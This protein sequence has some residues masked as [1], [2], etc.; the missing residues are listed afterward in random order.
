[1]TSILLYF[2]F[3]ARSARFKFL[4]FLSSLLII[5]LF[6]T[7]CYFY[8]IKSAIYLEH[9]ENQRVAETT[10]DVLDP[11]AVKN[12]EDL[13]NW[14]TSSNKSIPSDTEIFVEE[15]TEEAKKIVQRLNRDMQ[16]VNEIQAKAIEKAL[17]EKYS[18][19]TEQRIATI[20]AAYENHPELMNACSSIFESNSS[21][22]PQ[23][24]TGETDTIGMLNRNAD[25]NSSLATLDYSIIS[26]HRIPHTEADN[27][28][29]LKNKWWRFIP[30]CYL[31]KQFDKIIREKLS[32]NEPYN[33]TNEALTSIFAP[34]SFTRKSDGTLLATNY[35]NES[36]PNLRVRAVFLG[37]SI[38]GRISFPGTKFSKPDQVLY[39]PKD[40]P[41]FRL[42]HDDPNSHDVGECDMTTPYADIGSQLLVVRTIVCK[43]ELISK[44]NS[45]RKFALGVDLVIN[46]NR[47]TVNSELRGIAS[48]LKSTASPYENLNFGEVIENAENNTELYPKEINFWGIMT[49]AY[50]DLVDGVSS[51]FFTD[52]VIFATIIIIVFSLARARPKGFIYTGLVE[53]TLYGESDREN[54]V[55]GKEKTATFNRFIGFAIWRRKIKEKRGVEK[56]QREVRAKQI[57]ILMSGSSITFSL[58]GFIIELPYRLNW[59]QISVCQ[60]RNDNI[61]ISEA[62][63]SED[64]QINIIDE[65]TSQ[66]EYVDCLTDACTKSEKSPVLI[67]FLSKTFYKRGEG[68][69]SQVSSFRSL[70]K[71]RERELLLKRR[72]VRVRTSYQELKVLFNQSTINVVNRLTDIRSALKIS[73]KDYLDLL[74]CSTSDVK[75]IIVCSSHEE[76]NE[77]IESFKDDYNKIMK[78]H[79]QKKASICFLVT[80]STVGN[81]GF[82]TSREQFILLENCVIALEGVEEVTAKGEGAKTS[83][84][85]TGYIS[86]NSVDLHFYRL[87]HEE[88]NDFRIKQNGM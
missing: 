51:S 23:G 60:N 9:A 40:R 52:A 77:F 35:V 32:S 88:L 63:D 79:K 68:L 8:A 5:L 38:G 71:I 47:D 69:P 66:K 86:W 4:E 46:K 21:V 41:W 76:L 29:L 24:L 57:Y 30:N 6:G 48:R 27:F 12:Y 72:R 16:R 17:A 7:A 53:S 74:A 25:A 42:I 11:V 78:I 45:I 26:N 70:E 87:Y 61:S 37:V 28:D 3:L 36:D 22:L 43:G 83:I 2:D 59:Y 18:L 49:P 31:F 1:M 54:I 67:K 75:R 73:N 62:T 50:Y 58:V 56:V 85:L 44:E 10:I 14:F 34:K 80:P 13:L 20:E 15:V 64:H 84:Y 19:S 55:N 65:I 82:E 33:S 81:Y 39:D